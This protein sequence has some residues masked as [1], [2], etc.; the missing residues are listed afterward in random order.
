MEIHNGAF[1]AVEQI[2]PNLIA[3][4]ICR[5]VS[6]D[7]FGTNFLS[8]ISTILSSTFSRSRLKRENDDCLTRNFMTARK[9]SS[10]R[11]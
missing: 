11:K 6:T 10:Y 8:Y 4:K 2:T 5:I 3:D 1:I 7:K 9:Y